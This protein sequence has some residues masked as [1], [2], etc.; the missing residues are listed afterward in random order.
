[1]TKE[2]ERERGEFTGGW[3]CRGC[4]MTSG[5]LLRFRL[6]PIDE[7]F[8]ETIP[9]QCR[10]DF[11]VRQVAQRHSEPQLRFERIH[12][13]GEPLPTGRKTSNDFLLQKEINR[14]LLS[15]IGVSL[16]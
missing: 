13:G 16:T 15:F 6:H 1:M 14:P 5:F 12:H 2:N 3:Q 9:V 4:S 8:Q 11:I 7:S 10:V